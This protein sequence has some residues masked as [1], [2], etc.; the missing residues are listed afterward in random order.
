[1]NIS[2]SLL[3]VVKH[4]SLLCVFLLLSYG[5]GG[6]FLKRYE[7]PENG[8]RFFLYTSS[9]IGLITV[10]IFFFTL[11]RLFNQT[12]ILSA[13]ALFLTYYVIQRDF[14]I[15][16]PRKTEA[17]DKGSFSSKRKILWT[18]AVFML[19]SPFLFLPLYPPTA[20]D[21]ISYHLPY[22]KYYVEHNGLSVNPFLRY[23]LYAHNIDLL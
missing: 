12:F 7:V 13:M 6:I 11:F 8:G 2:A 4:Y 16:L 21:E 9:G 23:P 22:A 5:A 3:F 15:F 14:S 1:M 19:F 10:V 20:W 18:L 17:Q